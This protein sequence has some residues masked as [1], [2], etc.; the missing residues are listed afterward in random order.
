VEKREGARKGDMD[1]AHLSRYDSMMGERVVYQK[2]GSRHKNV[3]DRAKG[4]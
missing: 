4:Q 1:H 2:K 3:V